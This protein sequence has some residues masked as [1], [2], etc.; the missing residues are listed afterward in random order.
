MTQKE[1]ETR[2][3][4]YLTI[5][6]F[7][8]VNNMYL[9][10]ANTDKDVFCADYKD[11]SQ[12]ILLNMFFN[13]TEILKGEID[14]FRLKQANT[15]YFLIKKSMVGGDKDMINMAI[16]LIGEERYIQHK[17]EKGYNLFAS[18]KELII[19]LINNK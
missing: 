5:D 15:A 6:E 16:S 13:N 2:T 18:D 17:L 10:S 9:E 12:S 7:E 4:M 1:F 3:G 19:R 8:K 14:S 11:H